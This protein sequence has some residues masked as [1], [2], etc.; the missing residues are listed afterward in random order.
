MKILEF[1]LIYI[2]ITLFIYNIYI[3]NHILF[4]YLYQFPNNFCPITLKNC[5]ANCLTKN[6]T[7]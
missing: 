2:E 5:P 6:L 7:H 1:L 3:S 4:I